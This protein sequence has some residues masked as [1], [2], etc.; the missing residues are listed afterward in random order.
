MFAKTDNSLVINTKRALSNAWL[1]YI[2][3]YDISFYA[4]VI[5]FS[6]DNCMKIKPEGKRI[7]YSSKRDFICKKWFSYMID[8]YY[9][10]IIISYD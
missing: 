5:R 9:I 2:N 10:L 8:R 3:I 6:M 4:D 1:P 7:L